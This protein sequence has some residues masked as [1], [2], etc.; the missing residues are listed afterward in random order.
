MV[1]SVGSS[2]GPQLVAPPCGR[3]ISEEISP[4]SFQPFQISFQVERSPKRGVD[5]EVHE[6]NFL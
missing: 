2:L 6:I 3:S 5:R 1:A 4:F